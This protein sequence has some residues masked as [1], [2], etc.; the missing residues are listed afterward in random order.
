MLK[1]AKEKIS[2]V[3]NTM[4]TANLPAVEATVTNEPKVVL[5]E[6]NE[7]ARLEGK[8]TVSNLPYM[9]RNPAI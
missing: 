7:G 2:Y 6:P 1:A 8:N 5:H 4:K 9:H 3:Q